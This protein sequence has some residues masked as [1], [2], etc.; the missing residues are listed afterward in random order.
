MNP[1]RLE[2]SPA[3]WRQQLRLRWRLVA[4][5]LVLVVFGVAIRS[6]QRGDFFCLHLPA[7][8][9]SVALW[10]DG[11]YLVIAPEGTRGQANPRHKWFEHETW[12]APFQDHRALEEWH[13]MGLEMS[14]HRALVSA[15]VPYLSILLLIWSIFE[16]SRGGRRSRM[17]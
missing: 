3:R 1:N 8:A 12:D 7:R 17:T 14:L 10:P 2:Y 6:A 16:L 13:F 9:I 15:F 4:T 11:V 5:S